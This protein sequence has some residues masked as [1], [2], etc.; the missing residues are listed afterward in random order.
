MTA[1]RMVAAT[2]PAVGIAIVVMLVGRE[3]GVGDSSWLEAAAIAAGLSGGALALGGGFGVDGALSVVSVLLP[4]AGLHNFVARAS[5]DLTA[6][7]VLS[8]AFASAGLLVVARSR[9]RGR[10]RPVSARR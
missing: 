7:L 1:G 6:W 5:H 10:R 3:I 9:R 2:L 4:F 8:A